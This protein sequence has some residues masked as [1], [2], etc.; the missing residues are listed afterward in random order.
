M[1]IR[2]VNKLDLN[3]VA[4][5]QTVCFAEVDWR[6]DF[7]NHAPRWIACSIHR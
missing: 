1:A 2:G 5:S 7:D 3:I 6:D 4:V